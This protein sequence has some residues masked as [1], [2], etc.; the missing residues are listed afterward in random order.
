MWAMRS[1]PEL[2]QMLRGDASDGDIVHAHS[3]GSR[4]FGK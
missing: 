3:Q 4:C 1:V 2:D